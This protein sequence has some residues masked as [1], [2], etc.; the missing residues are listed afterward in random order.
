MSLVVGHTPPSQPEKM[1]LE[2]S[3]DCSAPTHQIRK[4]A[5]PRGLRKKIGCG[6]VLRE[7][8]SPSPAIVPIKQSCDIRFHTRKRCHAR[9]V[10]G[11]SVSQP[12]LSVSGALRNF[13]T[14]FF[15][16]RARQRIAIRLLQGEKTRCTACKCHHHSEI[17]AIW[18]RGSDLNRRMEVLQTSPLGLLG[19]APEPRSISKF[20][21]TC[22]C[23]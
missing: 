9:T 1:I 3:W 15:S 18:R 23:S 2:F 6:R 8:H 21:S 20:P 4:I 5:Q 17:R 16:W 22:Q 19:T 13:E 12:S 14:K 10:A 11:D 7:E